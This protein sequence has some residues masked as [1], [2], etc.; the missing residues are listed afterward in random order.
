MIDTVKKDR[1]LEVRLI[2]PHDRREMVLQEL[3]ALVSGRSFVL[4]GDRD[5]RPLR[6][7]LTAE[8]RDPFDWEDIEAGPPVWRARITRRPPIAGAGHLEPAQ[9]PAVERAAA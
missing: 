6:H 2:D 9:A 7:R 8:A 4:V 1:V 3:E 5:L